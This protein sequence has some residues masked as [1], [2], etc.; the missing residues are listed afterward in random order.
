M[1][2]EKIDITD[3]LPRAHGALHL[4]SAGK[5]KIRNLF[6][7]GSTKALFPRKVNGLECVVINTSGGLTGGDKF[8]NI[9]ECEDQ[10]K[11]TVTTQGCERIYKSNDGSAAI[12]ENKIVLKNKASIYWLPQETIVFDQGKIKREK[13]IFL[14]KT[15]L[16]G[17]ISKL[18]KRP[19]VAAGGSATAIIIFKSKRAKLLL[20]RFKD[21]LNTYSGVSLIKD[22]FLVARLI[23]PNGYELRQMLV[24]IITEITDKNLPKAWR[25]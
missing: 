17:N 23:A 10:S 11:L 2:L 5:S 15:R 13:I 7:Q 3:Q 16:S 12:V 14:D 6:Q 21:H 8:S 18:L 19:A 9:V 20:N 4:K 1:Y 24:P 25:L 22:N